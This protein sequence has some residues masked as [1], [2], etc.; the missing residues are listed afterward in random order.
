MGL[1]PTTFAVT[2]Q[3]ANQLR[4]RTIRV[5][6]RYFNLYACRHLKFYRLRT[7]SKNRT[8]QDKFWR[9][10]CTQY[11]RLEWALF[12]LRFCPLIPWRQ[13][14]IFLHTFQEPRGSVIVFTRPYLACHIFQ[15]TIFLFILSDYETV[16]QRPSSKRTRYEPLGLATTSATIPVCFDFWEVNSEPMTGILFPFV[17]FIV[18]FYSMVGVLVKTFPPPL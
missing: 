7:L 4:Y 1:E 5:T 11:P 3:R 15:A 8:L 2:G 13:Y 12:L 10:V 14:L 9:L 16:V 18:V 17:V 6:V